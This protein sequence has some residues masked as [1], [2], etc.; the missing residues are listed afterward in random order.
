MGALVFLV[1]AVIYLAFSARERSNAL[2]GAAVLLPYNQIL[3]SSGIPLLNIQALVLAGLTWALL[4]KPQPTTGPRLSWIPIALPLFAVVLI[5]GYL[6]SLVADLPVQYEH[7]L[8]P[9]NL[10]LKLKEKLLLLFFCYAAF[11]LAENARAVRRVFWAALV[12]FGGEMLFCFAEFFVKASK[13]TGHLETKNATG[14]FLA[15]HAAL[16][17]GMFLALRADRRRWLFLLIGLAGAVGTIGTRSRGGVLALAI[18]LLVATLWKN[19]TLF[20]LLVTLALTSSLWMPQLL[21]D[22]FSEAVEV[23]STGQLQA[24][25]TAA[26]R[27]EIWKAG[28]RTI[29]DHPLGI[30]YGLYSIIVPTYGLEQ[31][32]NRPNRDAHNEFVKVLVELG[33]LGLLVYLWLLATLGIRAWKLFRKDEDPLVRSIACGSLIGLVG[34]MAA[35]MALTLV[36]RLDISG[37]LWILLGMCARRAGDARTTQG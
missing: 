25:D 14:A 4:R 31:A 32:L 19:R 10:F 34:L 23:S 27:I 36:M 37:D 7:L 33:T 20:V 16:C 26:S 30:G 12:G 28:F 6:H 8:N 35:S 9:W 21:V 5:A 15:A 13:V 1:I 18:T 2:A 22:R 3:P 29:P 24:G 17:I 11:V